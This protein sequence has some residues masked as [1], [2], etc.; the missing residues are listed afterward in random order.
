M[1]VCTCTCRM[2]MT[3]FSIVETLL[4]VIVLGVWMS[5]RDK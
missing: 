2:S 4:C 5:L 1:A 3:I